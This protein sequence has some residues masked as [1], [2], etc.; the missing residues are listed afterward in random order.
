MERRKNIQRMD[1]QIK[2]KD[3]VPK[4]EKNEGSLHEVFI[5]ILEKWFIFKGGSPSYR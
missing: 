2:P 5:F 3:K 1:E 4:I